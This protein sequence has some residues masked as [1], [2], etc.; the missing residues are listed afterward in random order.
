MASIYENDGKTRRTSLRIDPFRQKKLK[1][2]CELFHK[3]Q[4]DFLLDTIDFFYM[5]Y[6]KTIV[7]TISYNEAMKESVQKQFDSY[8]ELDAIKG[9]EP[10]PSNPHPH[11]DLPFVRAK[12]R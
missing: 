10:K 3:T 7:G 6:L 8:I 4:N 12:G 2:I 9:I 5:D 11:H 1:H